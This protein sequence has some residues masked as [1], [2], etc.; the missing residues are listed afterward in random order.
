M[1]NFVSINILMPKYWFLQLICNYYTLRH[2]GSRAY[3]RY[4]NFQVKI[5]LQSYIFFNFSLSFVARLRCSYGGKS[6]QCSVVNLYF[7]VFQGSLDG[8]T[9]TNLRAHENDQ[10]ICKPGQFAS[11]PVTG[12]NALLSFRFFRVVLTG[13]TMDASNPWN[14]CICF[15][16][17]Y[18]YFH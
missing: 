7:H 1:F 6:V 10:T 9:W 15:L 14:F 17:L 12:P 16:E 13:P 8:K 2:D 5:T 4:W 11:W 3:M 18:G